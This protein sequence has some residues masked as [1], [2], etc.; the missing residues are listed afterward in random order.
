MFWFDIPDVLLPPVYRS[1]KDMYAY[2]RTLDTELREFIVTAKY[3]LRN[4]FIQTCDEATINYWIALIQ[5]P[6]FGGETTEDKRKLILMYLNNQKP[7]SEPYVRSILRDLYGEDKYELNI[8]PDDP[9]TIDIKIY[10]TTY[11]LIKQFL[12]WFVRMVPAHILWDFHQVEHSDATNHLVAGT[13]SNYTVTSTCQMT[14]GTD[15]LYLGATSYSVSW[16][17]L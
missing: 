13:T 12:F 7:T 1:I 9:Q 3:I 11:D 10:D 6:L 16:V 5:I 2:A 8:D 15:T 17:N 14:T 4:F